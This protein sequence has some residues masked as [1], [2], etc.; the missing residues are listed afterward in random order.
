MVSH[1]STV[2]QVCSLQYGTLTLLFVFFFLQT[3][4][5][6]H[7]QVT[8]KSILLAFFCDFSVVLYFFHL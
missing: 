1:L 4:D 2:M 6:V 8:K 7:E 3:L 5:L